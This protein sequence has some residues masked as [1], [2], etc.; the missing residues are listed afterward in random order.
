MNR[1]E[2][3]AILKGLNPKTPVHTVRY[4]NKD[5]STG[6]Y[7]HKD[8]PQIRYTEREFFSRPGV[9]FITKSKI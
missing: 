9:R 5:A 7:F 8:E 3:I 6:L 1:K 4:F 2:K